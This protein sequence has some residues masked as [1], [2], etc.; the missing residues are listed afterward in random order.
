MSPLSVSLSSPHSSSILYASVSNAIVQQHGGK[1]GV[2]STGIRGEGSVF[3]VELPAFATY[4]SASLPS[5]SSFGAA[6]S[7]AS[8]HSHD[9]TRTSPQTV[10]EEVEGE[11]SFHELPVRSAN[12]KSIKLKCA[13]V[14]DDSKMNRK[15][16]IQALAP[17]FQEILQVHPSASGVSLSNLSLGREWTRGAR[18]LFQYRH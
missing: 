5:S 17:Y 7:V 9:P 6:G 4:Q 2:S 14:V 11:S 3:Y 13:L 8:R 12:R 18:H 10:F 15:M 1:I 16:L